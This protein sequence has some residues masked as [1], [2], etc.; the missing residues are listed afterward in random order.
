MEQDDFYKGIVKLIYRQAD[1]KDPDV[2]AYSV[3]FHMKQ[4]PD[5]VKIDKAWGDMLKNMK[6]LLSKGLKWEMTDIHRFFVKLS[7]LTKYMKKS[8]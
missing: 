3:Y 1:D 8:S 4:H 5:N 7:N 6:I 2:M